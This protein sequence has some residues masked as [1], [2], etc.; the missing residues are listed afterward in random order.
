MTIQYR[1]RCGQ[2]VILRPRESTYLVV[3]AILALCLVNAVFTGLLWWKLGGLQA[4]TDVPA[5]G[6]AAASEAT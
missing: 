3:A 5:T 6:P 2:E 1:C 4:E